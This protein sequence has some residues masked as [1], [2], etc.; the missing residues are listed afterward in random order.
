MWV[1]ALLLTSSACLFIAL[2]ARAQQ[3]APE[4]LAYDELVQLYERET[5]PEALH[6]KLRRM[7][8]TPFVS[9]AAIAG[10][11]RPW[12]LQRRER[13]PGGLLK[14]RVRCDVV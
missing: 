6:D 5:L 14:N 12:R 4:L 1:Q 11:S 3:Q 8:T 13:A 10:R 7:L 9:N 2:E